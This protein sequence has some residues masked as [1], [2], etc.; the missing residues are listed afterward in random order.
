MQIENE[1]L[2]PVR[3]LLV[4]KIEALSSAA[5]SG[6][7]GE[8]AGQVDAIRQIARAHGLTPLANVAHGLETA[9]ARSGVGTLIDGWILALS[10]ALDCEPLDARASEALLASISLRMGV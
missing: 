1:G 6:R 7:I 10:D 4:R 8:T 2:L 3:A 5:Q 9:L